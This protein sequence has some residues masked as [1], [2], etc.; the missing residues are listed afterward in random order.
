MT[1]AE[2]IAKWKNNPLS[3]RAGAQQHFSDL[4]DLLGVDKPRDPDN[5]CFERGAKKAG[6]GDPLRPRSGQGWADVWKRGYFGWENK[7]PGRSLDKAYKQLTD[8]TGHLENPPL[9]VVCDRERIVIHTAFTGY[10]DETREIRI[11]DLIDPDQRQILRWVFTDP[12]KL[13]PEKSSAAITQEAAGE[14]STLAESM[15][16]RGLDS[17]RVAH[18]LVQCL[19][20]MFAEDESLLPSDLFTHLLE[21]TGD[22]PEKAM[23]RIGELFRLMQ[24][25]GGSYGDHDIAWFNGGLF[26]MVDVPP[27][28]RADI[29]ALHAAARRDWRAIDPTIFGTLFERGLDPDQRVPLGAHYTD[30]ATIQKLID[31]LITQPLRAEWSNARIEMTALIGKSDTFKRKSDRT[32]AINAAQ[33]LLQ[34]FLLRL[35]EFRALDPACGSGNFLYLS[36]K[37]LRDLEKQARVESVELGLPEQLSLATGPH[38]VLGIELNAFA[39]ELARVT[40]WIGD[41]QWCRRNGYQHAIDPILRPLDG[42]ARRDAIMNPDGTEPDWPEADVI[43]GNPPF[44]GGSKKRGALGDESFKSLERVYAGRV[45]AGA[46]LVCYWFEKARAQIAAGKARTAGLVAT[47]SIRGGSNRRVLERILSANQADDRGADRAGGGDRGAGET[48]VNLRIFNAWSDEPWINEGAAVRVSLIA[49]GDSDAPPMLDGQAVAGIYADLTGSLSEKEGDV[50]DLTQAKPLLKNDGACIR[51]LA[52]VGQFDIPGS[53]A[54][55]WAKLPN[56]HGRSNLDVISPWA[57]GLDVARRLSDTWLIDYGNQLSEMDAALYEAPFNHVLLHV[58]ELRQNQRDEKR[59]VYWWRLGRSGAAIRQA[60]APLA[61]YIATPMVAKYRLF[62]WLDKRVFPDQQLIVTA[63]ADDTTF[64]ILHSRF[65]ELWSLRMCTWLGKGNDPR[66]TPTT[67]FETFPFPEGLTP[68]DTQGETETLESGA[69]VPSVAAGS[70]DHAVQIAE[71]A[72]RLNALREN[73]LNPPEWIERIPEVVPGYPERIVPKPEHAAELKQRTLTN[74]YNK[75][76]AWLVNLH[77]ALDTA[78]ANAYGWNDDA[79]TLSDAEILRRLL[80]LNLARS[81]A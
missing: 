4:C 54:R 31:P 65:H 75:P 46:D 11:D 78:V 41:I 74:L 10:P 21:R 61:R 2:F 80:A 44:L 63:R 56:P 8:Y 72:H 43:V 33:T 9:L 60:L 27:L 19:F 3:E 25:K 7:K 17:Q 1:P 57:N 30:I 51:G 64:G 38:N 20:A 53:L 32:K 34:A 52:K 14:F 29:A 81:A 48:A 35:G 67:T 18:F 71:A 62:V 50:V 13:R 77:R 73:W 79:S 76:P 68:T 66:Y 26:K 36:I 58:K 37:A 47:N 39:A 69:I 22:D 55:Q 16:R 15:R 70:R 5:Y 28:T 42:I 24:K 49:F 40:V 12:E 45:P 6:G 23:K 59:K